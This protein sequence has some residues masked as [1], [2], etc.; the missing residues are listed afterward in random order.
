M[1]LSG[2]F[3]AGIRSNKYKLRVDWSAT[4]SI[5]DNTSTVTCTMYLVQ[6]SG[7]DLYISGRSNTTTINGEAK[8]WS[9]P[10]IDGGDGKTTKLGTVKSSAITHNSDGT[11]SITIK[12]VFNVRA[13]ISGTYYETITA[14]STITLDTIPRATTPTLNKTSVD[15]GGTI[16]IS[17]PRA[18]TAFTHDLAYSFAGSAYTNIATGQ[19][20]AYTWTVPDLA[21]RIPNAG[22]G[23]VTIRCITKNGSTV[24]GTKYATFKAT[25]PADVIPTVGTITVTPKNTGYFESTNVFIK[26][27]SQAVVAVSASGAKGSTIT[28]YTVS[29]DNRV[30]TSNSFTSSVLLNGGTL[31]LQVNAKD[32]RGRLSKPKTIDINVFDYEAPKITHFDYYRMNGYLDTAPEDPNGTSVTL[33][34]TLDVTSIKN[35]GSSEELNMALVTVYRKPYSAPEADWVEIQY[36]GLKPQSNGPIVWSSVFGE[37]F[38]TDI[39]YSLRFRVEDYTGK[40]AEYNVVIPTAEVIL[41]INADGSAIA[42]GKVSEKPGVYE[43]GKPTEFLAPVYGT[44]MGLDKL[45]QIPGDADL[46]N[47]RSVGCWAIYGNEDARFIANTPPSKVAGRLEVS[48]AT[49]EGVRSTAWSYLK[50]RFIPYRTDYPIY[51]RD[52]SRDT[53]NVWTFGE[54]VATSLRGQKVLFSGSWY[55]SAAQT[56]NLPEGVDAQSNGIVLV[57]SRYNASTGTADDGNFNS[58]FVPKQLVALMPGSGHC[59]QMNAVNYSYIASKYLY[60]HNGRIVGNDLNTTGKTTSPNGVTYENTSYVLRYVL[61]V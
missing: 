39:Q 46:N 26:G 28:S 40:F 23:V 42:F 4:Q 59:F 21:S 5:T 57:F 56:I 44:V 20:T 1:A 47:Y 24:L 61:G 35:P 34:Y 6:A 16:T 33:Q 58:F 27:I 60:I 53:T 29:L 17:L 19:A 30:Y 32:S 12:A 41:D 9:S 36:I 51:E 43:H 37:M 18:S 49:G 3:S 45:P 2:S 50:Q 13:T 15:M 11:K 48:A 8:T 22:S 7:F 38:S 25:V 55:M 52:V 14:E 54:W 31:T 10:A